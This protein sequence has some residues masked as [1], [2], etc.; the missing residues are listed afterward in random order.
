MGTEED[1]EMGC[2]DSA[3][4]SAVGVAMFVVLMNEPCEEEEEDELAS[5]PPLLDAVVVLDMLLLIEI[6]EGPAVCRV[7]GG[8]GV[9]SALVSW[10]TDCPCC[11][12]HC[13]SS[14]STKTEE[15]NESLRSPSPA[16]DEKSDEQRDAASSESE[17]EEEEEEEDEPPESALPSDGRGTAVSIF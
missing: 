17:E 7:P 5:S 1:G 9:L 15:A 6:R 3:Y 10:C 4:S 16:N 14:S 2:S 11:S 13:C 8:E 12:L